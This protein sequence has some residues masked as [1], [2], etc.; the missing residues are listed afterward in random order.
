MNNNF[1]N[2]YR[3]EKALIFILSVITSCYYPFVMFFTVTFFTCNLLLGAIRYYCTRERN[4]NYKRN[5]YEKVSD[6][7]ITV[8]LL[9]LLFLDIS[10]Y[11]VATLLTIFMLICTLYCLVRD[12]IALLCIFNGYNPPKRIVFF[13]YAIPLF[14]LYVI[15]GAVIPYLR[16]PDVSET[17]KEDFNVK[18]FYSDT[19]SCDRAAIIEDNGEALTERLRMIENAKESI[20]LSTFD[21]RSDTSGKQVISA[22]MAASDRGVNIKVLMD[23]FNFW[24]HMEGNPYFYALMAKSNVEIR[25]YNTATPLLPWK[26]MSRM[27]DKYIIVDNE[28]Y[29][30]GGRNT[31][32]YFLG[33]QKGHKNYD[34][35][36]LIYNT[37]DGSSSVYLLTEYF[38][39]VWELDCCDIWSFGRI[40]TDLPSVK[41]A[42]KE[43]ENIYKAMK[44]EHKEWFS[45]IDYTKMTVPT[46]NVSLLSNP[47][48]LYSKEPQVFWGLCQLMANAE[49]KVVIHTPYIIFNDMM[50]ESFRKICDSG[51]DITLM[52]NSSTNNGNAFGAV[53]Y[54]LNKSKILN[55]GIKILEYTG[56]ISYHGKSITIDDRLS[57]VGSF[58]MDM[59]SA[60]QDTEL[61]LVIDSPEL[62]EQLTGIFNEYHKDAAPALVYDGELDDLYASDS[63]LKKK[64]LFRFIHLFDPWLRFLL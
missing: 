27:H 39:T 32:N 29:M 24:T 13:R 20:I 14:I 5:F 56:G 45:A 62:N 7:L 60:Y 8:C 44:N 23:G 59:K 49:E 34:R 57:I 22:L 6:C 31:F 18:D 52:T 15:A 54:I 11:G 46:N 17:F 50:Y 42:A 28:V 26:G 12:I 51:V 4:I 10:S 37:G 16:Q 25:I 2:R 38:N 33:A 30:L 47:V 58:N 1:F 40:I 3:I 64:L 63:R 53:D 36:V 9:V 21:F 35:D 48:E 61:M 41:N 19:I 43:L 55:T